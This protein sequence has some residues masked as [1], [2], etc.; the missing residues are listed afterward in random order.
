MRVAR[1]PQHGQRRNRRPHR[2]TA[3]ART[4][5]ATT[6]TTS[7][8]LEESRAFPRKEAPLIERAR[9]SSLRSARTRHARLNLSL[10]SRQNPSADAFADV[11]EP[12]ESLG[13]ITS[14]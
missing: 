3:F 7:A 12:D 8:P 5:K 13:Q 14:G 2:H 4:S 10:A 9:L 11:V 6:N 1:C